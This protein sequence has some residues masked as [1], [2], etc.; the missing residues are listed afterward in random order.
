METAQE[1]KADM[2]FMEAQRQNILGNDDAY[3]EL[4]ARAVELDSTD[5]APA[6]TMGYYLMALAE[7]D[8]TTSQARGYAMLRRH[9]DAAPDDYYGALFYG[10]VNNRLGNLDESVRVWSTLD[11]LHPDRPDVALQL[12]QAL[13]ARRTPATLE[14]SLAV[15]RRLERSQG[16]SPGLTSHK[17]R[18]LLALRDTAAAFT[19]LQS[20][21]DTSP[22]SAPY[23]VFA[24]D[25]NMALSRPQEALA[26]Y[27][28][29]CALDST[30]GVAYYKRAEL[31][32]QQGDSVAFDREVTR[33]LR[34]ESLDLD[35]KTDIFT[36][37]IRRLYADTLQQPRIRELFDVVL[38]Q[39]PHEAQ[40]RDLY[41]S[42]LVA[43]GEL[44]GAAEQQLIAL[45]ADHSS[46]ERW[47]GA[48]SLLAQSQQYERALGTAM[49]GLHYLPQSV[50]LNLLAGGNA[51]Q[52]KRNDQAL[53]FLQKAAELADTTDHE[54]YSQVLGALGDIYYSQEEPDTAFAYYERAL[55]VDPGNLLAM[56][57]CAYHLA[58][59]GR[60]LERAEHLASICVRAN[61]DNDTALDTYAWVLFRRQDYAK[62]REM[63][64]RA[65]AANPDEE[66]QAEL[67]EHA[68]DIYYMSGMPKE[69]LEFWRKAL[70]LDPDNVLLQKKVK[71]K[72]HFFE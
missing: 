46:E 72:T 67:L 50:S 42:Y 41:A 71:H 31:Y 70:E 8:D 56:N 65:L 20:L 59:A 48:I 52:L 54:L 35:T 39:Y 21:L 11:S 47:R 61:P 7:N 55:N 12:A 22:T 45:D 53:Q 63:I 25:I 23:E 38:E 5:T 40:L 2:L 14:R 4:L 29:A 57:N 10:M 13:Q 58:V 28:R 3:F 60:D 66:P 17:I 49:Q 64:D 1:R 9:F 32:A 16:H 33:A 36:N 24:G 30:S 69:A 18:A 62:A 34:T 6:A 44:G 43:V 68:G 26:H 15:L 51:Q 27:D 19:E 37:Y